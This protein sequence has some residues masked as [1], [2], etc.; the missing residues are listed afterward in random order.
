[1]P[2]NKEPY[3]PPCPTPE[4]LHRPTAPT[5]RYCKPFRTKLTDVT[6]LP[7][8]VGIASPSLRKP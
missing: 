6:H 3:M 7:A 5:N 2:Q 1:M 4:Y 8:D